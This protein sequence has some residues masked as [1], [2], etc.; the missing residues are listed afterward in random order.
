MRA[1]TDRFARSVKTER[2]TLSSREFFERRRHVTRVRRFILAVL[3]ALA[4][5]HVILLFNL[6]RYFSGMF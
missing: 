4:A 3:F 5:G 1:R 6:P 2:E